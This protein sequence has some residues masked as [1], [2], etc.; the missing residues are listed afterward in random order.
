[1]ATSLLIKGHGFQEGYAPIASPQSMP[2]LRWMTVGRL[3]VVSGRPYSAH[4]GT[5]ESVIDVLSGA[6]TLEVA[7]KRELSLGN[8]SDPFSLGPTFICLPPQTSYSITSVTPTA[9]LLVVEA[10]ADPGETVTIVQPEDA[11]ARAV[12]AAN[13]ARQVWPGTATAPGTKRLMVGETINP[14]GGWSSYPP[15][16]HDEEKPPTE[17]IY[18]EVYFFLFKPRGGFGLQR[19]YERR[20]ADDAINDTYAVEDGDTIIIPRG[21]HPVVAAP[22]YQMAY[23]WAL[24][25]T[26]HT[27]GAWSDDPAFAWVRDVEAI[28][29][30]R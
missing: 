11:P 23:V 12:G 14:P 10:P 8:R 6:V 17:A 28:L 18:E 16:K 15:H 30:S 22:G 19:I 26:G 29:A 25:G 27:Y 24:C 1:M 5:H 9:D 3:G 2:L 21:Y 20:E 4:T 13:W 7:G